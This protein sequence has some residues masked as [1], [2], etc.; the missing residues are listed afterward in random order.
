MLQFHL[1][2]LHTP[3][4]CWGSIPPLQPL[5]GWIWALALGHI[6]RLLPHL[7]QPFSPLSFQAYLGLQRAKPQKHCQGHSR[8]EAEI[9]NNSCAESLV[10]IALSQEVRAAMML[11]EGPLRCSFLLKA[12]SQKPVSVFSTVWDREGKDCISHL[13]HFLFFMYVNIK[14]WASLLK[15]SITLLYLVVQ[16]ILPTNTG[17]YYC[18][19]RHMTNLFLWRLQCSEYCDMGQPKVQCRIWWDSGFSPHHPKSTGTGRY[20]FS[21]RWRQSLTNSSV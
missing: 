11:G 18:M 15:R 1:N 4:S 16:V 17:K 8:S 10:F 5:G 14:S 19:V 7:H 20:T 2:P 9:F 12:Y 3:W 21:W 13:Q 6:P